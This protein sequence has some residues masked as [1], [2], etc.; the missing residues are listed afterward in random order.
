M[1][2][3]NIL[4]FYEFKIDLMSISVDLGSIECPLNNNMPLSHD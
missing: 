4:Y 3:K 2:E 1:G